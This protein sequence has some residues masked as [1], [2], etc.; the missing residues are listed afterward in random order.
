MENV[1][2]KQLRVR[3]IDEAQQ[4]GK[5]YRQSAVAWKK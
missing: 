1:E 2:I 4:R 5:R 3:G